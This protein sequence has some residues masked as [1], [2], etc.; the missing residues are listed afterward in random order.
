[1]AKVDFCEGLPSITKFRIRHTQTTLPC[2]LHRS[3]IV[4]FP[5]RVKQSCDMSAAV[6]QTAV[7]HSTLPHNPRCHTLACCQGLLARGEK[8]PEIA[9]DRL[10]FFVVCVCRLLAQELTL[11][12]RGWRHGFEM[13][14]SVIS[15]HLN[16]PAMLSCRP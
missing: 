6:R 16:R 12:L 11:P 4:G 14:M 1:M 7:D 13:N 2:K 15:C 10:Q 3:A 5:G 8:H 9:P